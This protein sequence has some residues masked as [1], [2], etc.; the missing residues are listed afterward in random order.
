MRGDRWPHHGDEK[1]DEEDGDE[2]DVEDH[3]EDRD[4]PVL[5]EAGVAVERVEVPHRGQR[6][7][8]GLHS[9]LT[10]VS[11]SRDSEFRQKR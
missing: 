5:G 6:E 9:N 4:D 10:V 3:E 1:V 8:L 2:Y 11:D 7:G